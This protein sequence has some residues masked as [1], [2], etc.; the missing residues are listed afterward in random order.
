MN[1]SMGYEG[2]TRLYLMRCACVAASIAYGHY[3]HGWQQV[4]N[5]GIKDYY[6]GCLRIYHVIVGVG[7]LGVFSGRHG[8]GITRQ[9]SMKDTG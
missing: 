4:Q 9:A 7:A 3:T 5:L 2:R 1:R 8:Y 6:R